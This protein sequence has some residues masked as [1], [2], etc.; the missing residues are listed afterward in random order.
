[1]QYRLNR[2]ITTV[3]SCSGL[4]IQYQAPPFKVS[5][6]P[7]GTCSCP[8]CLWKIDPQ[9]W[10]SPCVGDPVAARNRIVRTVATS[11]PNKGAD[12]RACVGESMAPPER[13]SQFKRIPRSPAKP[14]P[15]LRRRSHVSWYFEY[16]GGIPG[17]VSLSFSLLRF[18]QTT[19]QGDE[20]TK[21]AEPVELDGFE[22]AKRLWIGGPRSQTSN[23]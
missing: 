14:A 6:W 17:Q 15:R 11:I 22:V 10:S 4:R 16:I 3:F 13:I 2:F 20:P 19:D 12:L 7:G 9:G 18:H 21:D 5:I 8:K 1:M 23:P